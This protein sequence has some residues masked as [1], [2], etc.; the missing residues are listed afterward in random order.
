MGKQCW[1]LGN[2]TRLEMPRKS[3]DVRSGA[4]DATTRR[5]VRT[6]SPTFISVRSVC[7]QLT[8]R[9][10][11]KLRPCSSRVVSHSHRSHNASV[12]AFTIS[13]A[14]EQR[15]LHQIYPRPVHPHAM[16]QGTVSSAGLPAPWQEVH[17]EGLTYYWNTQSNETTYDR[18][19]AGAAAVSGPPKTDYS[20][21][22]GANF[23]KHGADEAVGALDYN[24]PPPDAY[25]RA[26]GYGITDGKYETTEDGESYRRKHE[27]SVKAPNGMLPPD[28][29]QTFEAGNWPQP[30]LDAVKKEGYQFPTPIQ[31]Q[32]WPIALQGYDL[33]SVAKTGSGKT[34]GYVFPGIMHVK[35]MEGGPRPVG[36]TV[37]V[38]SPTREL[39]T[40]IQD[41]TQK[42]GRAIGMFSVC[43]Y[44]GAPK[45]NQLREVRP[46]AFPKSGGAVSAAP[47]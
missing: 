1:D 34:V 29:M 35:K 21:L 4:A 24:A 47:R 11:R 33:I 36:P 41:E 2:T 37:C 22:G 14:T 44:G 20:Y 5:P 8:R 19:V 30:L 39:A 15:A 7:V 6:C 45:G 12:R 16:V 32:S 38:L 18:P 10:C 46:R 25:A 40:Q 13:A 17:A 31:A 27:I 23:E 43:L 9:V 42:F 28:P 3:H 26:G